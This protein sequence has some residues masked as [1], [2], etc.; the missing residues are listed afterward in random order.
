MGGLSVMIA[1]ALMPVLAGGDADW[2]KFCWD[3]PWMMMSAAA[4]TAAIDPEI[5]ATSITVAM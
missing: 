1:A 3:G 4:G 5:M 2:A